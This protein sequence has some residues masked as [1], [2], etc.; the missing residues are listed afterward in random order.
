MVS[1]NIALVAKWLW[2]FP[3]ELGSLWHKVIKSK[4]G[5]QSNGWDAKRVNNTSH[6]SPW[7]L[8]SLVYSSFHT[9]LRC[10][11]GNGSCFHF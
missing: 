11:V 2:E 3:M 4:Y 10:N 5:L 1:K 9:L 7:K 6:K 8:I